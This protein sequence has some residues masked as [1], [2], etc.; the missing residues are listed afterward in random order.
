M[1]WRRQCSG[2]QKNGRTGTV[3]GFLTD[4]IV[5]RPVTTIAMFALLG[6]G[7]TLVNSHFQAKKAVESAAIKAAA[8]LSGA[9]TANRNFYSR[10]IVPRAR[11]AGVEVTHDYRDKPRAIPLPTTM[12]AELEKEFRMLAQ[13]P[14]FNVF[15]DR[16]LPGRPDREL[17]DFEQ[18][19][20]AALRKDPG[21][22]FVRFENIVGRNMVRYAVPVDSGGSCVDCGAGYPGTTQDN[23]TA[24]DV[25]AVQQIALPIPDAVA[26]G[27]RNFSESAVFLFGYG[28]LGLLGFWLLVKRLGMSLEETRR[29]AETTAERNHELWRAKAESE[30]ANRA[31]S[32]F[33]ANMSHELRTPLNAILGFSEIIKDQ[34]LGPAGQPKYVE[35]ANDIHSSGRHLLEVISDILDLS[36]VEAGQVQLHE[37]PVALE[38]VIT[39]CIRLI[40]ARTRDTN[41]VTELAPDLPLLRADMTKLKQVL[42]NLLSNAVKFTL[43]GGRIVVRA[44]RNDRGGIV[45]VVADTGIGMRPEDIPKALEPFSQVD[46]SI[47]RRHQGTGLGLPLAKS[48]CEL[49]GGSL[50]IESEV[51]E[52]TMVIVTFPAERSTEMV[53]E[54]LAEALAGE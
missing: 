24:G 39:D 53:P 42:L 41:I 54:A 40:G 9:I 46:G 22:P 13:G 21:K 33:L 15:S 45:I 23:R 18:T 35:Y 12:L 32:E 26:I 34:L 20:L 25:F 43:P 11:R 2:K 37:E 6:I 17:D 30:A 44:R 14:I 3:S 10:E 7:A 50:E 8:A 28:A 5:R 16:P 29:M 31:K 4:C 36:K 49:H 1:T 48:L 19:A 27:L 38:P 51:G 47:D 52:G